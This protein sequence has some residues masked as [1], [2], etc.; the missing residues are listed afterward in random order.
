MLLEDQELGDRIGRIE[1][2][3]GE[4]ETFTDPEARA[5]AAEMVQTLLEV[6][7]ESLARVVNIAAQGENREMLGALTEDELISHLLILHDLHPEDVH[8]RVV[9]GLDEVR[10]YLESHGGDVELLGVEDGVARLRLE[11]SC[12][13]CPSSTMTLKLAIEEAVQKAA[14]DIESVEAEGVAEPAPEPQANL[15]AGPTLP[16]KKKKQP[17][18]NGGNQSSWTVVDDLPRLSSGGMTAM[19]VSGEP[20]LFLKLE[21]DSY[22]Y[23]NLC[24]GCAEPLDKGELRGNELACAGCGHR[25]DVRRAGRCLD[26]PQLYLEPIPLLAGEDG[27]VKVAVPEAV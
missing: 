14:P 16:R 4:I 5:K 8:T 11:G 1:S 9:R 21:D 12:S 6:Y 17:E 18:E 7:G 23:R 2:L 3:L 27:A 20:I 15:V 13:G 22:A 24:S 10:P 26:A 25:Y 19:E